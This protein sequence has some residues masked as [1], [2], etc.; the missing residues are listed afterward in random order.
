MCESLWCH[1]GCV[2]V[3][4]DGYCYVGCVKVCGDGHCHVGCVNESVVTDTVML[5]V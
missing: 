3:C 4:G 2:K 1:V 5:G